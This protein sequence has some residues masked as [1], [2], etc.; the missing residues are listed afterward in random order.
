MS[1]LVIGKFQGDT[2]KFRQ[3][4]TDRAGEFAKIADGARSAGAIHHRFGIGDGFVLIVDEWGSVEQFQQFFSNPDLQ[5]FIGSV[6]AAPAPPEITVSEA[7]SLIGPVLRSP[8]PGPGTR[9]RARRPGRRTR[10]PRCADH[11]G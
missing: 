3:A 5:A 2:A 1:V 6:G 10:R 9:R 11:A 7:V 8:S 4:L